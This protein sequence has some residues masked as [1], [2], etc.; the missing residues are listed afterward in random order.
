VILRELRLVNQWLGGRAAVLR[1]IK[2]LVQRLSEEKRGRRLI[3]IV[4]LGSG[5][6]DIPL[7]LVSW[8][9]KKGH[10]LQVLAV[11][12]SA[13][14]CQIA[15]HRTRH[16]PEV[17]VI[18]GNAQQSFLKQDGCDLVLCSAFLHHFTDPEISMLMK[19][20]ASRSRTGIIVSDLH[21]H[22]LAYFGIRLLTGLLSRSRVIR[23]DGP[24][25]VLKGFR[26]KELLSILERVGIRGARLKWRWAFRW[27]LVIPGRDHA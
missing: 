22:P 23:H 27:V 7:A 21:R 8:A 16:C 26:R 4:D 10:L 3:R 9:K 25:S 6:A 15:Q 24:L 1:E 17:T 13:S 5:S 19:D 2:S 18:Q 20:W 11:D 12:L 14:V